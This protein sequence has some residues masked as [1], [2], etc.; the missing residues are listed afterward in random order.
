[1]FEFRVLMYFVCSSSF[2]L[3]FAERN[4]DYIERRKL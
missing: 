1:M 2:F 4:D 3:F